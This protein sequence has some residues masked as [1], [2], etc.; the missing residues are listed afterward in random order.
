V[1]ALL[2]SA[3]QAGLRTEAVLQSGR[4]YRIELS[5]KPPPAPAAPL[6]QAAIE[7]AQ[8]AIRAAGEPLA[9]E[10]LH[11]ATYGHLARAGHLQRRSPEEDVPPLEWLAREVDATL[12]DAGLVH[13]SNEVPARW[14]LAGLEPAGENLADRTEAATRSALEETTGAPWQALAAE[15]YARVGTP[16][17]PDPDLVAACLESYASRTD[18]DLWQ[19]RAEDQPSARAAERKE[20]LADLQHLGRRFGYGASPGPAGY[21]LAWRRGDEAAALFRLQADAQLGPLLDLP[22]MGAPRYLVLPGG[23]SALVSLKLARNPVLREALDERPWRF[24]KTRHVRQ[25]AAQ[26]D[27]E[28]FGLQTI[29]G[30]DPIVEQEDAQIPM[31]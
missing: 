6:P 11:A 4:A 2:V 23:R 22:G 21:D 30:L 26:E 9:W 3:S 14:W 16:L 10:A 27:V 31:F 25:L 24:V 19:L 8:G 17:A 28:R 13:L 12:A 29:I 7:A 5:A 20:L 1:E 18:D 15:I